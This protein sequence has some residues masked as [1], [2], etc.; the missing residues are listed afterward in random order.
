MTFNNIWNTHKDHLL[1]FI[2]SKLD[3]EQIAKDLLQD[4]GIKLFDNLTRK[5][6]IKNHKTWL[7]Q[8]T[9]NTIA[10]YYRKNK[11]HTELPLNEPEIDTNYSPCVC[12]LSGFII[13]NY[14]PEKYSTPLYL[15]A[16]EQKPQQDIAKTLNLSVTATKSRIQRGRKK[17]NKLISKCVNL[18]Y[19]AKGEIFDFELKP[20][21]ELPPELK[22]EMK[23]INLT[24]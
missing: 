13:Q 23:R 19:N 5:T 24:L 8:V 17:L 3:N 20:N 9:R 7:F 6:D 14:L 10:D 22:I 2:K 4:V 16:I 18:S 15:S 21:C 11:T 12:D 1:N